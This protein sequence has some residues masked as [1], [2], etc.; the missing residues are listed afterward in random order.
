MWAR[1]HKLTRA[2]KCLVAHAEGVEVTTVLVANTVLPIRAVATVDTGALSL[3]N[4]AGII[5][6]S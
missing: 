2:K 5:K 4:N 6:A 1:G 3:A